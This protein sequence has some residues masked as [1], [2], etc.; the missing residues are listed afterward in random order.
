VARASRC[1]RVAALQEDTSAL[2]CLALPPPQV[3]FGGKV[4]KVNGKSVWAPAEE[5][6]GPH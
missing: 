1:P 6:S 4:D 3:S 5:V 2:W